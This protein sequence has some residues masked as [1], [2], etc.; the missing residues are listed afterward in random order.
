MVNR[1][2]AADDRRGAVVTDLDG[3]LIEGNSLKWMLRLGLEEM[4]R[5]LRLPSVL[6][7]LSLGALAMMH[8]VSH[9]TMKYGALRLIGDDSRVADRLRKLGESRRSPRVAA[10]LEE[11]RKRGDRILLASAASESYIDSLWSG[12]RLASPFGGPDLRGERKRAA[13][14]K[15]L[16]DNNLRLEAFLTDHHDDLPTARL[17]ASLGAEIYLVNPSEKTRLLFDCNDIPAI[18]I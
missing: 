10:I 1:Q 14:E 18:I 15:W 4:T 3:T 13:V 8:A 6:A 5:R 17:A 16:N 2:S 12:E 7:V 11:A 9:E